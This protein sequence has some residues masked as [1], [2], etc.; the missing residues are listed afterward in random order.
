MEGALTWTIGGP[1]TRRR[2]EQGFLGASKFLAPDGKL[3]PVTRKRV[4]LFGMK[5]PAREGA[6]IYHGDTQV[7]VGGEENLAKRVHAQSLACQPGSGLW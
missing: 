1:K 5:A 6:E 2:K 4:G 3:L 7:C